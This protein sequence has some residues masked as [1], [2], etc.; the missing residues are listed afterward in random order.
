MAA[1]RRSP[2][3][4]RLVVDSGGGASLATAL[5]TRPESTLLK[6]HSNSDTAIQPGSLTS[7]RGADDFT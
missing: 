5:T 6:T 2:P 1:A 7:Q 4:H 3:A